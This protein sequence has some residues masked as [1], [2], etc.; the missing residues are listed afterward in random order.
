[1]SAQGLSPDAVMAMVQQ[2]TDQLVSQGMADAQALFDQSQTPQANDA[3]IANGANALMDLIT[4]GYDPDKPADNQ[5]MIIAVAGAVSLIIPV[6]SM[7]GGIILLGDAVAMGLAN[8]LVAVGLMP[9]FGCHSSGN[10]TEVMITQGAQ[11][12]FNQGTCNGPGCASIQASRTIPSFAP[13]TFGSIVMPMLV[14]DATQAA[15]CKP[16]HG[17]HTVIAGAAAFWNAHSTG[18]PMLVYVPAMSDGALNF[19]TLGFFVPGQVSHAF[20]SV[21]QTFAD[22]FAKH[23]QSI[24]E[25]DAQGFSTWGN[26]L[27]WSTGGSGGVLGL[28]VSSATG[29]PFILALSGS[30][31]VPPRA[32][33]PIGP[34]QQKSPALEIAGGAG[35]VLGTAAVATAGYALATKQSIGQLL[36]GLFR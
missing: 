1:M 34:T 22:G 35:V 6:G 5:K 25:K 7:I 16:A 21:D 14:T 27:P 30:T 10:W 12:W 4:S 32:G 11:S 33:K 18:D 29:A 17:P 3:R 8:V 28:Q 15:N 23:D 19:N 2:T 13:G 26:D 36:K 9:A 31:Y 20:Q 24:I